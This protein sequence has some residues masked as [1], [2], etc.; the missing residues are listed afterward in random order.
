MAE[1]I[2]LETI[3]Y[4]SILAKLKLTPEETEGARSDMQKMLDYVEK[5][6]ELDTDGVEPMIPSVPLRQCVPGRYRHKRGCAGGNARQRPED[7]R[8][9][10]SCAEDHRV[11][12][13]RG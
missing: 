11:G 10:V 4:V 2:T 8:R 5:L 9:P 12:G 3:D 6:N 1:T 13:K 7:K